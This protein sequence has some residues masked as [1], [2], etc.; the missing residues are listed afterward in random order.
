SVGRVDIDEIDLSGEPLG[1][2]RRDKVEAIAMDQPVCRAR[3]PHNLHCAKLRGA[4]GRCGRLI[5]SSPSSP[6]P[7]KSHL[8]LVDA[9][10][11]S[12]L[13]GRGRMTVLGNPTVHGVVDIT[14]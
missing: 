7:R 11:G 10:T 13:G 6:W 4:S 8:L 2:E 9:L 3:I 5:R 14:P 12:V 1:L